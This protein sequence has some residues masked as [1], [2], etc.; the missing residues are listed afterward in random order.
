MSQPYI[1]QVY[2]VGYN[3]AARGFAL[4][5]GQLLPINQ[6]TALFSLLGTAFGG[7]GRIT[8]GLPDLRGRCAIGQ[9]NGPGLSSRRL[10]ERG[11]HETTT[12][13]TASMPSHTHGVV[14]TKAPGDK[15]GPGDK[16]LAAGHGDE[17]IYHDGPPSATDS[18]IM[19]KGMLQNT[20]G[21]QA[22]ANMQPYLVMNY[23]IA[24]TGVFPS[25]S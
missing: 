4:T 15:G 21:G 18:K 11:G 25:R 23:Q 24:L 2:L 10:G 9:G 6:Y 19:A 1:G 20:G 14:A 8:F 13:T 12:L 17:T 22:H 3:F 16:Y 7:D 5:E